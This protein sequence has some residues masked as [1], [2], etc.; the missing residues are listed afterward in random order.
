MAVPAMAVLE[1]PVLEAFVLA[2]FWHWIRCCLRRER[3]AYTGTDELHRW[4]AGQQGELDTSN[5]S[6]IVFLNR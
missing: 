3:Q 2:M 5:F 4:R 1:G 6:L